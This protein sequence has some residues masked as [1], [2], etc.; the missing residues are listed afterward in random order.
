MYIYIGFS[1]RGWN[2]HGTHAAIASYCRHLIPFWESGNVGW[3]L[4][5]P[6]DCDV[7]GKRKEILMSCEMYI[8]NLNGYS[9]PYDYGSDIMRVA[10][11]F[12]GGGICLFEFPAFADSVS[13]PRFTLFKDKRQSDSG[14]NEEPA[15]DTRYAFD[16]VTNGPLRSMIR[17]KT[18]NW[19]TDRAA[20]SSSRPIQPFKSR[21]IPPAM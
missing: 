18:M 10:S 7:F 11:S 20:M 19:K 15:V 4:W 13:R 17:V 16:V 6:T 12:G 14:W 3:K 1:Q 8:K 9:V 5:Y 2:E 21:T